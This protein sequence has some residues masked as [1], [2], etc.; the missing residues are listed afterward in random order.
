MISMKVSFMFPPWWR[1]WRCWRWR[2]RRWW[3]MFLIYLGFDRVAPIKFKVK[4]EKKKPYRSVIQ[5]S[6]LR[7][8]KHIKIQS[9]QRINIREICKNAPRRPVYA[10]KNMWNYLFFVFKLLFILCNVCL[11]IRYTIDCICILGSFGERIVDENL[12]IS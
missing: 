7:D 12:K 10:H 1:W 5:G 8:V 4:I 3:I 11:I 6:S 9:V 2:M